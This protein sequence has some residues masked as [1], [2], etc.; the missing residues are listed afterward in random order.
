[1]DIH[2][3]KHAITSLKELLRELAIVTLGILIALSLDGLLAWKHHRDL[4]Q[5]A[6]ANILNELRENQAEL[7]KDIQDLQKIDQQGQ[8]LI[9][10]VHQLESNRKTAVHNADYGFSIAEL[11]ATSLNTAST[12]GAFSYM[13]YGEVKRY[14]E[15]YDLQRSFDALQQRALAASLDVE[16]LFTLLSRAPASLSAAELADAERRLGIAAADV[17]ALQQIAAPL[18]QR[19]QEVLKNSP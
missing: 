6:R 11:H 13:S 1:M 3:P 17:R 19:Y 18:N 2:V 15:V 8:N 10:L 14:T 9:S 4:V 16:G 7:S 12:T 5:E